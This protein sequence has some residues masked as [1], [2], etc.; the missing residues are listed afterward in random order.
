MELNNN[1]NRVFGNR[2]VIGV[3]HL[4]GHGRE[5]KI[6]RAL[7]E[8][9]IFEEEGVDAALVENF[10]GSI[11]DVIDTLAEIYRREPKIVIGVNILPNEFPRSLSLAEGYGGKFVQLDYVAGTY[12]SS[13]LDYESYCRDKEKHPDIVVLGGVWPKYY[14]PVE[15]SD[16]EED[17]KIGM[18]RAEAVV[19]TGEGT[20]KETPLDKIKIFRKVAGDQGDH[21]VILGAG[22]T[23][24]NAYQQL[25]LVDGVIIGT[26]LKFNGDIRNPVDRK[27]VK[28]YMA[29]VKQIRGN[30]PV[31][32]IF[33]STIIM[34]SKVLGI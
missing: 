16:L 3:I 34:L 2:P 14:E 29:A 33:S 13:E 19:V 31:K 1:F 20:G 30:Y 32:P 12:S 18:Q 25:P 8:I 4:M 24:Q 6:K 11:Q 27:R 5:T 9:A 23:I 28:D 26:D 15:G 22:S 21:L 10:S 17:I 7:E